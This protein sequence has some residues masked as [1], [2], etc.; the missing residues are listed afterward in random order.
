MW[1]PGTTPARS[2]LCP[3]TNPRGFIDLS[4]SA[5]RGRTE[6][7]T[8]R[9]VGD[10]LNAD[11]APLT[12]TSPLRPHPARDPP[13]SYPRLDSHLPQ[14]AFLLGS[15]PSSVFDTGRITAQVDSCD[16]ECLT[17]PLLVPCRTQLIDFHLTP[18]V[19]RQNSILSIPNRTCANLNP[20][21][22]SACLLEAGNNFDVGCV[23]SQWATDLSGPPDMGVT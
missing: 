20:L 15:L 3:S 14:C 18:A 11:R 5:N 4:E 7:V 1:N 16:C 6:R 13:L 19:V 8:L 10:Q 2:S 22:S 17:R 21:E 12:T 9:R 23:P